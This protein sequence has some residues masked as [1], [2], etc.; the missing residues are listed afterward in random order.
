MLELLDELESFSF[1]LRFEPDLWFK[2]LLFLTDL[3]DSGR[4]R[5]LC[6]SEPIDRERGL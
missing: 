2:V 1:S 3:I 6:L 5:L 4:D